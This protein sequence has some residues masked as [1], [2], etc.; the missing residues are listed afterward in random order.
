MKTDRS[1]GNC[2]YIDDTDDERHQWEVARENARCTGR[3]SRGSGQHLD[4]CY[5]V[6]CGFCELG[7]PDMVYVCAICGRERMAK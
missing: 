1:A 4:A 5:G 7:K 2:I 3:D 6:D